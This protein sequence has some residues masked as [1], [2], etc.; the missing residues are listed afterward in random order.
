MKL[1]SYNMSLD[2]NKCMHFLVGITA[3]TISV[4]YIQSVPLKILIISIIFLYIHSKLNSCNR[5]YKKAYSSIFTSARKFGKRRNTGLFISNSSESSDAD[6]D[7]DMRNRSASLDENYIVHDRHGKRHV[8]R[9]DHAYN[10]SLETINKSTQNNNDIDTQNDDTR[11]E[12]CY[13]SNSS[14]EESYNNDD[15]VD[16]IT[17]DTITDSSDI[18]D[19]SSASL[20]DINIDTNKDDNSTTSDT[21]D[22]TIENKFEGDN[23]IVSSPETEQES[24]I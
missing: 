4:V 2:T 11:K 16:D 8:L 24:S 20:D 10:H 14:D 17:D 19:H 15:L 6:D 5:R 21:V 3:C 9:H 12:N 23:L 13:K 1:N 18:S 22:E 7:D